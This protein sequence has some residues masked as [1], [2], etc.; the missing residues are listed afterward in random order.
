M[1]GF[2]KEYM[3][4]LQTIE[5]ILNCKQTRREVQ[6]IFALEGVEDLVRLLQ[7][8]LNNMREEIC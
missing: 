2:N 6:L 3:E 8:E 4:T 5:E 1:T 7:E